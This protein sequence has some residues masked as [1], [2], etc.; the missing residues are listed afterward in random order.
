MKVSFIKIFIFLLFISFF[1][2]FLLV[3]NLRII[4]FMIILLPLIQI[5]FRLK[6]SFIRENILLITYPISILISS[7]I[8]G[9]LISNIFFILDNFSWSVF[10]SIRFNLKLKPEQFL[11]YFSYAS[12]L[13]FSLTLII[14]I[15][16]LIFFGRYSDLKEINGVRLFFGLSPLLIF[17]KLILWKYIYRINIFRFSEIFCLLISISILFLSNERKSIYA[18]LLSTFILIF[19]HFNFKKLDFNRFKKIKKRFVLISKWLIL[20][21]PFIILIFVFMSDNIV[22]IISQN[23]N[24]AVKASNISRFSQLTI[25]FSY[26]KNNL[27]FG[28]PL[29]EFNEVMLSQGFSNSLASSIHGYYQRLVFSFGIFPL[30]LSFVPIFLAMKNVFNEINYHIFYIKSIIII[31]VIIYILF[32]NLFLG[33][34]SL[35]NILIYLPLIISNIQ[36]FSNT[37]ITYSKKRYN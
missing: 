32:L 27:L 35:S 25:L 26:F 6:I 22:E 37:Q 11:L 10:S 1:P 31:P 9:A 16:H 18:F 13:L 29:L 8:G 21:V 20:S 19:S 7:F 36:L 2:F 4:H 14:F 30:L 24:N 23:A 34:G 28:S 17:I 5:I 12:Y 3:N 15:Y 33:G